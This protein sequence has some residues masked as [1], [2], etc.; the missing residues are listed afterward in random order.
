[1]NIFIGNL[2]ITVTE[3][4]LRALFSGYGVI[5]TVTLVQDRDT[6]APRG[7]AFIEMAQSAEAQSAIAAL[8]GTMLNGRPLRVNE[9]RPKPDLNPTRDPGSRTHRQ[10]RI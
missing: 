4:Q 1:M 10:H 5:H 3:Q 6:G 8:D 7:M 9:C 2:D